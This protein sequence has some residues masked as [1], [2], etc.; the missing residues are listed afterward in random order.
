MPI[1]EVFALMLEALV[2][3]SLSLEVMLEALVEMLD[4]LFAIYYNL[5]YLALYFRSSGYFSCGIIPMLKIHCP[6]L[7]SS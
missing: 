4:V 2:A 3:I 5:D 6:S 7:F 1:D